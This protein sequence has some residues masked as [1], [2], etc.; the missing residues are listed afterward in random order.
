MVRTIPDRGRRKEEITQAFWRM[1]P[2][3]AGDKQKACE[4]ALVKIGITTPQDL[5]IL[6]SV[7]QDAIMKAQREG[8]AVD[9]LVAFRAWLLEKRLEG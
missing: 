3:M 8:L 5:E 6:I 9:Q 7:V 2:S 1:E 4:M